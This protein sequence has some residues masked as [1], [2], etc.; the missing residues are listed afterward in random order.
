M[1][2]TL[3][4]RSKRQS[5]TISS[6]GR[7][8]SGRRLVLA[9]PLLRCASRNSVIF[10]NAVS[11]ASAIEEWEAIRAVSDLETG[12]RAEGLFLHAGPQAGLAAET[13][14]NRDDLR[15]AVVDEDDDDEDEDLDDE[16]DDL[17]D[18]DDDE[19]DDEADEDE[20]EEEDE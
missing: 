2:M 19:L 7:R 20:E 14:P 18:D 11:P 16:G 13:L 8:S 12:E 4:A 10:A 15:M 1:A 5:T 9:D 3:R 17:V 6:S